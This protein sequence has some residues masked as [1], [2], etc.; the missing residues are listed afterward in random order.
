MWSPFDV[1]LLSWVVKGCLF[2]AVFV[3]LSFLCLLSCFCF[4]ANSFTFLPFYWVMNVDVS[5]I[6]FT[7]TSDAPSPS[8][9]LPSSL[10]G[11]ARGAFQLTL[12]SLTGFPFPRECYWTTTTYESIHVLATMFATT[13][14]IAERHTH[15]LS[16]PLAVFV[17]FTFQFCLFV[18]QPE[19]MQRIARSINWNHVLPRSQSQWC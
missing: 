8:S 10:T 3:M 11:C 7:D 2:F 1:A 15:T 12:T 19:R 17:C 13:S 9:I 6:L 14:A 4:A 5:L 18:Q 16:I